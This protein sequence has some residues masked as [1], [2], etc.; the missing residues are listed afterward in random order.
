MLNNMHNRKQFD[1]QQIIKNTTT[2]NKQH[3][4]KQQAMA[5][6]RLL[7]TTSKIGKEK[8]KLPTFATTNSNICGLN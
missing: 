2:N 3:V 7:T 1:E 4:N 6:T 8:E 5:T